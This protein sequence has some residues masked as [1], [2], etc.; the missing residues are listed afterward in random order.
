MVS[1]PQVIPFRAYWSFGKTTMDVSIV[2]EPGV[3]LPPGS[4]VEVQLFGYRQGRATQSKIIKDFVRHGKGQVTF[5]VGEGRT[6]N[7]VIRVKLTDDQGRGFPTRV[8]MQKRFKE[9][10]WVANKTGVSDKVLSPWTKLKV[11]KNGHNFFLDCWERQYQFK[12]DFFPSHVHALGEDILAGPIRLRGKTNQEVLEWSGTKVKPEEQADDHV[13]FSQTAKGPS[14]NLTGRVRVE[15][16]GMIRVDWKAQATREVTLEKLVLEIPFHTRLAKYLYSFPSSW[17]KMGNAFAL[18]PKGLTCGFKPFIWMGDEERGFSW[19]CESDKNWYLQNQD[20]AITVERQG[21][22]TILRLT[23][24]D[25]PVSFSPKGRDGDEG[26]MLSLQEGPVKELRYTFG[27]QATPLKKIEQDAWDYRILCLTQFLQLGKVYEDKERCRVSEGFLD[28]L[29]SK[30]VRT[31]VLF[32]HWTD[33]EAYTQTLHKQALKKTI[34]AAHARGLSVLFYFGFLF[35]DRA[36]EW[37]DLGEECISIPKRGY[38]FHDY[39]PQPL[40]SA[41]VVCYRNEWQDFIAEGIAKAMDEFDID[42]VYLDG[43]GYPWPCQNLQHGCGYIRPNESIGTTYPM[44]AVRNLMKRI[45]T[46]VK[47]RKPDGQINYHNSSCLTAPT[48][49][50]TTSCWDGEQ[51]QD[52]KTGPFALDLIPL[53]SFRCEFMGKPFGIAAEFLCYGKPY[54]FDQI[55]A[56]TLLHDVPVRP[57]PDNPSADLEHISK[58]WNVFDRFGKKESA[59]LPYWKN[60]KTVKVSSGTYVSLYVH[61]S[62]NVLAVVSNLTAK[63]IKTTIQFNLRALQLSAVTA[64]DGIT[65]QSLPIHQGTMELGLPSLAW[66]LVWLKPE[67]KKK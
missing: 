15:Y 51:F 27:F 17:G 40:Q 20:Q 57:W 3:F 8:V 12:G 49:A 47:S 30:G 59:W 45:Y 52:V 9:Y 25:Q 58:I 32:E 10:D 28:D 29:K 6:A 31:I 43:T 34:K 33:A 21:K 24:V 19:F 37:P 35:S 50:W 22:T 64:A 39:P 42:G 14:L 60:Q 38:P 48:I 65:H 61:P 44:F 63:T 4:Q 11:S 41:W 56:V 5:Q 67:D 26:K 46:I 13:V 23:L 7:H 1:D 53:D 36:P 18:P 62:N 55:C 2:P 16:D 66:K 54:T